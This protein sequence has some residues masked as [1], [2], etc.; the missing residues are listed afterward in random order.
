MSASKFASYRRGKLPFIALRNLTVRYPQSWRGCV[1][2]LTSHNHSG[3]RENSRA[4]KKISCLSPQCVCFPLNHD[5]WRNRVVDLALNQ[6]AK[7]WWN[8]TI[9]IRLGTICGGLFPKMYRG[10]ICNL[11]K[12]REAV[13]VS[14]FLFKAHHL[15][16]VWKIVVSVFFI[17]SRREKWR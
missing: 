17:L 16:Y 14:F 10:Q 12:W 11:A 9:E 3:F 7:P 5:C 15:C 2:T 1:P 13:E 6:A 8:T 4:R